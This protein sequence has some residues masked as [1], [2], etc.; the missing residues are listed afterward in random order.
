M[1]RLDRLT[2]EERSWVLYDVANSAFTLI[3][4]TT[5][6]PI[7]FKDFAL[8]GVSSAASTATWAFTVSASSLVLAI[9]APILG[10][11]AD[12]KGYKKK[13]WGASI[14]LGLAFGAGLAFIGQG[15]WL[16]ATVLYAASSVAY[17][18]STTFYDSF[19]PDITTNDRMDRVSTLG[20]GWGYIGSVVPFLVA[21]GIIFALG[22]G[23][24][25]EISPLG[26]KIAFAIS[27]VWWGAFSL[28]MARG[29][30]Q[31]FGVESEGLGL[32][33]AIG[34]AFTR[35]WSTLKD[36]RRDKPV[37]IFLF[38]Y[39]FYIDGVHTI[40]TTATAYGR[41]LGLS[42]VFL[43]ILVLFIQVVAWPFAILFGRLSAK[44]GR[45]P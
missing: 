12:Y 16:L 15:Q 2:K 19:L 36:A 30:H 21:I 10:A 27:L 37:F 39:F 26:M 42:S 28:P 38:A 20:F 4:I 25:G 7:F 35:L 11:L 17:T 29:V 31:R 41:D 22:M 34:G 32:G 23:P 5:F 33:K 43:V 44:V 18:A 8:A 24:G 3:V 13:F 40:I 6:M 14:C 1:A 9:L 45:K